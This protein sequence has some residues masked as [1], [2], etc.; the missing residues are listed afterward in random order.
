MT[1]G[2]ARQSADRRWGSGESLDPDMKHD[3]NMIHADS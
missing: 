1:I 3:G 2:C